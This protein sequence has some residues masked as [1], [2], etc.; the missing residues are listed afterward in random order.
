[1]AN[2]V[3]SWTPE[4]QARFDQRKAEIVQNKSVIEAL[5]EEF[6]VANS[7]IRSDLRVH[8]YISGDQ[9]VLSGSK[10]PDGLSYD[11]TLPYISMSDSEMGTI[12]QFAVEVAGKC[13]LNVKS[14]R[15]SNPVELRYIFIP[16]ES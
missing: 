9:G 4:Q 6:N 12:A 15:T 7:G 5:C 2:H 16:K 11:N 14:D 1:M 8:F 10:F 3:R 13:N